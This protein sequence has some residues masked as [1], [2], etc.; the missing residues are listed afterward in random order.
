MGGGGNG[1]C[2]YEER[3]LQ[4]RGE[5][6]GEGREVGGRRGG[7]GGEEEPHAVV[8]SSWPHTQGRCGW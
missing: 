7:G 2:A 1:E 8:G 6:E 3:G 5:K 4:V